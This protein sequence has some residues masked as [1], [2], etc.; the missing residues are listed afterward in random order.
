MAVFEEVTHEDFSGLL[1]VMPNVDTTTSGTHNYGDL[2][3]PWIDTSSTSTTDPLL[4]NFYAVN[5]AVT[6]TYST[7]N[8]DSTARLINWNFNNKTSA[9]LEHQRAR[10]PMGGYYLSG[11]V[12][13]DKTTGEAAFTSQTI[14]GTETDG[15]LQIQEPHATSFG[16]DYHYQHS[17][18]TGARVKISSPGPGGIPP[19][20]WVPLFGIGLCRGSTSDAINT[21]DEETNYHQRNHSSHGYLAPP[22]AS[23]D[24]NY[25]E[26]TLPGSWYSHFATYFI[27]CHDGNG[28]VMLATAPGMSSTGQ[29]FAYDNASSTATKD[30][31][32]TNDAYGV[33]NGIC[34]WKAPKI[35]TDHFNDNMSLSYLW[36]QYKDE[37]RQSYGA[38][39]NFTYDNDYD[40]KDNMSWGN[41]WSSPNIIGYK[42]G[43]TNSNLSTPEEF[44]INWT[45]AAANTTNP[46]KLNRWGVYWA[47]ATAH[48]SYNSHGSWQMGAT[49][50]IKDFTF[51]NQP[52]FHGLDYTEEARTHIAPKQLILHAHAEG[53]T[54]VHDFSIGSYA[55]ATRIG[56]YISD[57]P[58]NNYMGY[59]HNL[60]YI[61][62]GDGHTYNPLRDNHGDPAKKEDEAGNAPT[63][64]VDI[65]S[66]LDNSDATFASAKNIG[67][68][69]AIYLKLNGVNTAAGTVDDAEIVKELT[70]SIRG[71]EQ[72]TTDPV[73]L[74]MSLTKSDK[75]NL[76]QTTAKQ[77]VSV[78]DGELIGAGNVYPKHGN[79]F[80]VTFRNDGAN[81]MTYGNLKDGYLKLWV[82]TL[83]E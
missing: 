80:T 44:Y 52:V 2:I 63:T 73:V 17:V 11:R 28:G 31:M 7:R 51:V 8:I 45:T 16:Q 61:Y 9:K 83:Q 66:M 32:S 77:S 59:S 24:D 20:T 1:G 70:V 75:T 40:D 25:W 13:Q 26:S 3:N 82:E 6:P 57:G 21:P 55:P 15:V 58:F 39:V 72:M 46:Y 19:F 42:T 48:S 34:R 60:E 62:P 47:G 64:W 12:S 74:H 37:T 18:Q 4:E 29:S 43:V 30:I 81:N 79:A 10:G 22:L 49:G 76:V 5:Q 69:D 65:D 14:D 67:P 41:H 78:P 27:Y 71:Y 68:Q 35:L 36:D 33:K 54:V 56:R 38:T 23:T 50:K 53:G